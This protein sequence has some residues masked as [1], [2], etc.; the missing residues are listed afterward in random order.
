MAFAR[1]NGVVLHY[2]D[3]GEEE[4]TVV[5][6]ANSLGTDLRIWDAVAE[7]LAGRFR[8]IRYDKRGH[9]LSGMPAG[10][11][12]MTDHVEDLAGL[13]DHQGVAEAIVAGVSVGGMIAQGLAAI[14][15]D[16]VRSLVLLDTAHKIGTDETW[17]ARIAKVEEEGI[18]S[19]AEG[20][21]Q[22]WFT[23]DFREGSKP[24]FEGYRNMLTRSPVEGYIATCAAIRDCNL[25]ESTRALR[26][27]A[28][29]IA[30]EQDG[31]TPP[32]LVR[33]MARLIEGSRFELIADAGH[34]PLIERPAVIAKMITEFAESTG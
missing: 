16:L 13:L 7:L 14:R 11:Y 31:S 10:P 30:G 3:T 23:A 20:I 9:G 28:L 27:P 33:S 25:T 26:I 15:P 5:A 24:F 2:H 34:L 29:C 6:F 22:G 19:I 12:R 18:G 4:L 8:L 17:N 1:I 21:L 32:D